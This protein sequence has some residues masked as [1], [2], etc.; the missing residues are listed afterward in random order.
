MNRV[1]NDDE[2]KPVE[3]L[4]Q[5]VKRSEN[6]SDDDYEDDDFEEDGTNQRESALE[7]YNENYEKEE[8]Q[9]HLKPES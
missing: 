9:I 8:D 6:Q 1:E 5:K 2:Q 7:S 3:E 4:F